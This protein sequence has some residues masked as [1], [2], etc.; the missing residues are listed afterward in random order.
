MTK[1]LRTAGHLALMQALVEA[2]RNS[3]LTQQELADRLGRSQ[4]FVAKIETGERRVE[5]IELIEIAQLLGVSALT[6]LGPV[7]AA[8]QG[9]A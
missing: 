9:R 7:E 5:V 8:L 4:S 3:G 1:S 6:L 2:R